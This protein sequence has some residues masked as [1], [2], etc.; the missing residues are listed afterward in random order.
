[1]VAHGF[2]N[3]FCAAILAVTRRL[4]EVAVARILEDESPDSFRFEGRTLAWRD[5]TATSE[6]VLVSRF[7]FAT[8]FGSCSFDEPREDLRLLGHMS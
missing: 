4:S 8:S 5:V 7:S 6:E 3:F 1:M 2:L